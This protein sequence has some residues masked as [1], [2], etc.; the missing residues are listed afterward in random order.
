MA[1][2]IYKWKI[3]LLFLSLNL[4]LHFD[5]IEVQWIAFNLALAAKK[6]EKSYFFCGNQWR[7]KFSEYQNS[8]CLNVTAKEKRKAQVVDIGIRATGLAGLTLS[9]FAAANMKLEHARELSS[10]SHL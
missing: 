8:L 6:G 5:L 9:E 3:K 2:K 4:P 7:K 10:S 1:D